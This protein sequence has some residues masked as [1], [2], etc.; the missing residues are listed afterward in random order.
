MTKHTHR[1]HCQ[2]CGRLQAVDNVS[3]LIAKHGYTVDFHFFNGTCQASDRKPAEHD[4]TYTHHM[5]TL[6]N[7]EAIDSDMHVVELRAG[8]EVPDTFQRWNAEKKVPHRT[9]WRTGGYDELPI[10]QATADERAKRINGEILH[11]EQRAEGLRSHVKFLQSDILPLLGKALRSVAELNQ[12]IA[13][14]AAPVV[15]VKAAKV[16][17]T[18]ATKAARKQA[19]D[20][21]S[22][23]FDKARSKLQ[24]F[25]L[26]L[27]H[28]E[29]TEN[30]TTVYWG[31]NQLVHWRPK[32]AE[33]ALREFP[34]AATVIEEINALAA[35]REA[36]KNAP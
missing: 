6:C 10:A 13:K 23:A 9:G 1:G 14:P 26:A 2:A 33:L 29:R 22:C 36:V 21:L 19:L 24:G 30:K 34:Q 20:K 3:G 15:D 4:V 8:R 16:T 17:G 27:P 32:H 5:I 18:F 7:S 11:H 31:P 35:A 28:A 25:Y 12:P